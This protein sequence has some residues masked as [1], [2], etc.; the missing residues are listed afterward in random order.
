VPAGGLRVVFGDDVTAQGAPLRDDAP[1]VLCL[2]GFGG[3]Q[4]PAQIY[5]PLRA[6]AGTRAAVHTAS[7]RLFVFAPRDAIQSGAPPPTLALLG[8]W[9]AVRTL[10]G[11]AVLAGATAFPSEYVVDA[12]GTPEG[13]VPAANVLTADARRGA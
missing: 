9:S 1:T 13:P 8:D 6:F 2:L 3:S 5:A 10:D 4:L 12:V 7:A 11:R